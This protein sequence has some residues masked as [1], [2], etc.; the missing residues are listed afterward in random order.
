[1]PPLDRLRAVYDAV[2]DLR[3]RSAEVRTVEQAV[4]AYEEQLAAA[5]AA[6][7]ELRR[8]CDALEREWLQRS[9]PTTSDETDPLP[10]PLGT[11]APTAG[12]RSAG[13]PKAP[14]REPRS[15]VTSRARL[16]L[17]R[18]VMQYRYAWGLEAVLLGQVS[19]IVA[20]EDR[21]LGEAVA[22][23]PW[24]VFAERGRDTEAAYAERLTDWQA[25]LDEYRVRLETEIDILETRFRGSWEIWR[26]WRARE[27]GAEGRQQWDTFIADSLRAQG[28]KAAELRRQIQDLEV[29]LRGPEGQP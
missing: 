4:R 1:M 6:V 7:A 14:P 19:R 3:R 17:G 15:A 2:Q 26:L 29:R 13:T 28:E 22:L 10:P 24:R 16:H 20:N 25:A 18:L 8:R 21:P 27:S 12:P 23:L 9:T 5:T 11:D